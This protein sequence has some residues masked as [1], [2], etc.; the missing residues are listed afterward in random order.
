MKLNKFLKDKL[1][2]I[3]IVMLSIIIVT[4][5]QCAFKI[6]KNLVI[7]TTVTSLSAYTLI[8]LIDYWRKKDFYSK[9]ITNVTLLDKA[10][11]VLETVEEPS[12]YEGKILT[13]ILYE[14][15][16][17]M[18]E[19][20]QLYT[21]QVATFKEFIEMWIHE[22]K[23][24]IASLSLMAHN[25][26]NEFNKKQL[27]QL[28][29]ISDYVD[30][31]LY[32]VR[33]ENAEKDYLINE[34]SLNKVITSVALKNKDDF[35]ENNIDFIVESTTEKVLTDS[36]WLEFIL[37]QI[38][39]NAIKYRNPKEKKSYIKIAVKQQKNNTILTIEDNGIGIP[40]SD[41]N[42]VFEKSFTGQNG[43]NSAKSTGIGLYLTKNL[44][45]KLGHIIE[46]ESEVGVYTRLTIIFS[47]NTL[48]DV[49]R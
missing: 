43:R 16:K 31:V 8:L 46:I 12:F 32:Y 14:T 38:I 41:L 26:K 23:I 28:R 18:Y 20:I 27:E 44:C 7:I 2:S 39:N 37:N 21:E 15:D 45:N 24:P 9:L 22:V 6:P 25:H 30:Q 3:V 17:S 13:Q 34:V 35:L 19:N 29:R 10:Y 1:Y 4:L 47:K 49:V 33:S 40:Q 36:K 42:R 11:L 5:T 48:F